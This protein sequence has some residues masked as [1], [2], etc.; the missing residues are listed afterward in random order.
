MIYRCRDHTLI[1]YHFT[2][3]YIAVRAVIVNLSYGELKI[4]LIKSANTYNVDI[5]VKIKCVV[6]MTS[7]VH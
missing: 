6:A 1:Q 5:Y 4:N 7:S 2:C 3:Q